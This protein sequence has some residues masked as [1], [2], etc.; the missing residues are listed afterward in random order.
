VWTFLQSRY[1]ILRYVPFEGERHGVRCSTELCVI[2]SAFVRDGG[3]AAVLL[4]A[5][6]RL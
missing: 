6:S 5:A 4:S 2:L 3:S 1:T